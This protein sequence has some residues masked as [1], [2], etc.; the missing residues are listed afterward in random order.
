MRPTQIEHIGIAVKSLE[1]SIPTFERL[2]GVACH[3]IEE[4][5]EQKVRTAFFEIGGSR[6]ELLESTSPEGPVGRFIARRGEGMHHI[7][8]AVEDLAGAIQELS[9]AGVQMVESEPVGGAERS[10]VAFIHPRSTH[11][12]LV[13]LCRRDPG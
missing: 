7:A 9:G 1:E 6:L 5:A 13:E 11:G 4:V 8:L 3:G 12:V 2:L 10:R